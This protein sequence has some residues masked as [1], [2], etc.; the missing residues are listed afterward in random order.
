MLISDRQDMIFRVEFL[1]R[2][3]KKFSPKPA[4]FSIVVNGQQKTSI[5]PFKLT[6]GSIN[7]KYIS[8]NADIF[9][10]QYHW[11]IPVPSRWFIEPKTDTCVFIDADV[12]ACKDLSSLYD[13]KKD[14]VHG[15]TGPFTEMI[16]KKQWES[17]GFFNTEFKYYFN[18]GVVIVPSKH[19]LDIGNN[20]FENMAKIMNLPYLPNKLNVP[21]KYFAGQILLA[22]TLKNMRIAMNVMPNKFNWFDNL[23]TQNINEIVLLHYIENK[24]S[25]N[26]L[27]EAISASENVYRQ[28]I[29]NVVNG[30]V[31]K[32]KLLV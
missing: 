2:S 25:I 28:L 27:S 15:V 3:I 7:N 12:I 31:E 20:I 32:K 14:V 11:E 22:Y 10:C 19:M 17:I 24:Y 4:F 8:E 30:L 5:K 26:N 6:K 18:F 9:N 23:P 1:I 29:R 16:T 13:L 21:P